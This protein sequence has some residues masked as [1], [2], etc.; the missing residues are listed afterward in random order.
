MNKK[1]LV[2]AAHPDDEI[3]GCGGTIAKYI[4]QGFKVKTIILTKG[5]SSRFKNKNYKI[6]KL[7]KN[8]NTS[9]KLAN[10]AIGVNDLKFFDL[11][12]NEFD[13]ISL[14]SIVKI[15]EKEIK[16]FKP[17]TIFTH[18]INDLNVDHQYTSKAVIIA[19]RPLSKSIV[20]E[21]L[22]FEIN[23]ST[24]YQINS[25][26]FQFQPNLF[27]DISK[28][29]MQKKKALKEY[30]SEMMSYP[31]SRSIKSIINRNLS[32]GNSVGLEFAEAFQIVRKIEK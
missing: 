20:R 15:I 12:D 32:L 22:F 27:V 28:T 13:Q 25:N 8:L 21:I 24:D 14:L 16:T 4:K 29:I 6:K 17:N 18:Y 19:A 26:G 23:S 7:Q 2:V 5:I 31:N 1:I 10:K 30:N 9:S 11:P 3:L